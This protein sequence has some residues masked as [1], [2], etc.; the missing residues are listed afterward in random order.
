[1]IGEAVMK[2]QDK[3]ITLRDG[4]TCIL[5]SAREEDAEILIS[6]LKATADET[7]FLM[8]NAEEYD[9]L[10]LEDEKKFIQQR[11]AEERGALLI[12]FIDGQHIG[13][14]HY[15]PVSDF[16]R[17]RHRCQIGIALYQKY[18]GFGI[19]KFMLEEVL[20]MAEKDGYEQ[21]ELSVV[22]ENQRAISLYKKLGFEICGTQR[23]SMKYSDGSYADE[24]LMIKEL[25]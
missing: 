13:N 5:R 24:Y 3:E 18:C 25:N 12:G 9:S 11:E 4:R 6:Y 16:R 21:A 17:L 1:M 23:H 10:T 15:M 22:T 14:C 8:R 20:S 7:P 19:G 2:C